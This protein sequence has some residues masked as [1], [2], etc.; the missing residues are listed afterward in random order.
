[1]RSFLNFL[2]ATEIESNFTTVRGRIVLATEKLE[3]DLEILMAVD[4][5]TTGANAHSLRGLANAY[6]LA[7]ESDQQ[8]RAEECRTRLLRELGRSARTRRSSERRRWESGN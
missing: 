6:L 5:F 3:L 1:M 7:C 4:R 2:K 8:T